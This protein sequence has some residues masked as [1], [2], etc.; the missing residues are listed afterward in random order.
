MKGIQ[1][2]KKR[3][4]AS[5]HTDSVEERLLG[6]PQL[7]ARRVARQLFLPVFSSIF[8][9]GIGRIQYCGRLSLSE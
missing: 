4:R 8:T 2:Q 9:K 3:I 6:F 1:H 7:I 5:E